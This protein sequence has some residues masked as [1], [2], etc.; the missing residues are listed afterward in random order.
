MDIYGVIGWPIKHSLSPAMHN[1]AFK[2]FGIDAE[3]RKFEVKPAELKD[4]ILNQKDVV[5][6]NI[7]IPHKIKAIEILEN[8]FPLQK[9]QL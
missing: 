3:Y 2:E 8:K 9:K 5:G 7:T 4:F 6:F 1:A